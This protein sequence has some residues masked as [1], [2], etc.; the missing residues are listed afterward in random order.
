[1]LIICG[2]NIIHIYCTEL[3]G[4]IKEIRV[5]SWYLELQYISLENVVAWEQFTISQGQK[6]RIFI[7][8]LF[9]RKVQFILEE[10]TFISV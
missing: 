3:N 6:T 5:I 10:S 8:T 1:M 2:R 4:I 7:T 9:T